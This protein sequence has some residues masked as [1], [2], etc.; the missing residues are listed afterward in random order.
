MLFRS[1]F[2]LHPA[3]ALFAICDAGCTLLGNWLEQPDS[4]AR[5]QKLLHGVMMA[6]GEYARWVEVLSFERKR[7]SSFVTGMD[8]SG[9]CEEQG[10]QSKRRRTKPLA[11]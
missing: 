9:E 4:S 1:V 2:A 8:L 3:T 7:E 6:V 10:N 5:F 11:E